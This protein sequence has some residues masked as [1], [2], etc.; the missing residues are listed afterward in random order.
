MIDRRTFLAAAA[1][2]FA[3]ACSG[4]GEGERTSASSDSATPQSPTATGASTAPVIA[5]PTT[6]RAPGGPSLFVARA[7]TARNEV[8]LTFHTDGDVRIAQRLLDGLAGRA[9]ITCFIVGSW[10][11]ANPT[12]A[13][14]LLDAGHELANHTYTHPTFA[15]LSRPAMA[16]EITRCRDLLVKLTGNGGRFFRPSG[17][18]DGLA[19]PAAPILEEAGAA[20]Y[21][22]VLGWDVEPF[23]YKD[24]GGV[25]VRTR[26]LEAAKPGSIV[27]LHFGH[28]G[29]ADAIGAM[30]DGFDRQG[31]EAVTVSALMGVQ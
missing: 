21:D 10:L 25:A 3:S 1:A 14:K 9:Q 31:I 29:T 30:L 20:G 17:T 15:T 4:G 7:T 12:W 18:D 8:A 24:P 26:V 6:I 22:Y 16:A 27:S 28:S 19:R 2:A 23:D 5:P 13:R 11:D